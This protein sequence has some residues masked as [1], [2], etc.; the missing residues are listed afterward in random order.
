M[1]RM[2]Y[3]L[4]FWMPL[5][6]VWYNN[7]TRTTR[8]Q[9]QQ[10]PQP[11]QPQHHHHNNNNNNNHNNNDTATW[12][13]DRLRL[14]V[15]HPRAFPTSRGLARPA[16]SKPR[17]IPRCLRRR[18]VLHS[19]L[20]GIRLLRASY[21]R[22]RARLVLYIHHLRRR[23]SSHAGVVA[24]IRGAGSAF[25]TPFFLWTYLLFA[26]VLLV[27]LLIAMFNSMYEEAPNHHRNHISSI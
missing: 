17:F 2:A 16:P 15:Q 9:E 11:Q 4:I 5:V 14:R 1:M 18:P 19:V 12:Q 27:N 26:L 23:A 21:A 6:L 10:Q 13:V 7:T 25:L 20:G 24:W 8:L 3:K 22:R